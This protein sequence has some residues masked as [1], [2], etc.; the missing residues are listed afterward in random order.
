MRKEKA[1][2]CKLWITLAFI[3]VLFAFAS[4]S[5]I[6]YIMV[7]Q[8]TEAGLASPFE[9]TD[10]YH[11]ILLY[12]ST[13]AVIGL[14]GFIVGMAAK[15]RSVQMIASF[16]GLFGAIIP[17]VASWYK[18]ANASDLV[19]PAV[20]FNFNNEGLL[21]TIAMIA[22][23]AAF[24]GFLLFLVASLIRFKK[25]KGTLILRI[26]GLLLLVGVGASS[27]SH[28]IISGAPILDFLTN[29]DG[30]SL[31]LKALTMALFG[32]ALLALRSVKEE[33]PEIEEP[34]TVKGN[35]EEPAEEEELPPVEEDLPVGKEEFTS[36][37]DSASGKE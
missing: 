30:I 9:F 25:G 29:I 7:K 31:L 20:E 34:S 26:L 8:A 28:V 33:A 21:T 15:E 37:S 10:P 23:F 5:F 6:D 17:Y 4:A 3:A 16:F 19:P 2:F 36:V 35:E 1:Q 18:A 12:S 24:A 11:Q 32:V 22:V 27:I 13:F 14:V